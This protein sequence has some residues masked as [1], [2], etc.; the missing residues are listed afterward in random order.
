[1][2]GWSSEARIWRSARNRAERSRAVRTVCQDLQ[3]DLLLVR[4]RRPV[5]RGTTVLMPPSPILALHR[6]VTDAAGRPGSAGGD[7]GP[8]RGDDSGSLE[9]LGRPARRRRAAT[10]PRLRRSR[11][12]AAS[13]ATGRPPARRRA[14]P[15][16]S[17]KSDSMRR[18]RS[19]ATTWA[20]PCSGADTARPWR[21]GSGAAPWHSRRRAPAAISSCSRPPKK[22]NSTTFASSGS[23]SLSSDQR[24]VHRHDAVGARARRCPAPRR[25]PRA[26][27]RRRACR[28]RAGERGRS[29]CAASSARRCRRS[30]RGSASRRGAG[31]SGAG[32]AS[33]IEVVGLERLAGALVVE[34]PSSQRGAARCRRGTPDASR[35][36]V[37]AAAPFDEEQRHVVPR[38]IP[39][40]LGFGSCRS[41]GDA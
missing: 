28:R 26:A 16:T 13:G 15:P 8:F 37:V 20:P 4:R 10:R 29:G 22:R 33:W 21:P 5:P 7:G 41:S 19:A 23:T 12:S 40:G 39:P 31:R 6:V 9:E 25:A 34:I 3:G 27:R 17:S 14:A 1:M 2:P 18:Q 24:L 38:L 36:L 30:G 35:R 32:N 11:S